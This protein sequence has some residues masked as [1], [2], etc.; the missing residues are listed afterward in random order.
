MKAFG[1]ELLP[2]HFHPIVRDL[3]VVF[4]SSLAIAASLVCVGFILFH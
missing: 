4:A 3:L 1:K 2:L